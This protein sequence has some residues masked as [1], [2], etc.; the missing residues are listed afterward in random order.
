MKMAAYAVIRVLGQVGVAYDIQHTM[1]LLGVN[2][3]NHCSVVPVNDS[4]TGMLNVV[5]DYCTF[6]VINKETLAQMIRERGM[7]VGDRPITDDYVKGNSEFADIAA[8][9]EAVAAG[10]ASF[11]D[12]KGMKTVFRLHPPIKGY[13]GNKRPYKTGGALGNRGDNIND[14]IKRM[15]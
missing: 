10:E 6:G 13:E 1:R 9:A 15:L 4:T 5:K 2:R 3:A 11:R 12:V 14:L 7:S 8:L